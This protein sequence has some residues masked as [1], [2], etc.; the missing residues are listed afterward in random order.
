MV[1][2]T[3]LCASFGAEIHG[4]DL[5]RI[6]APQFH[7]LYALWKRHHVILFRGQRLADGE[8]DRF[9]ARFGEIEAQAESERADTEWH[10]AGAYLERPPFA[11]LMHAPQQAA[12]TGLWLASLS[13][14]LRS[15]PTDLASR[16]R[17][18]AMRHA[19]SLAM[20]EP[21]AFGRVANDGPVH[22]TGSVHPVIVVQPESGEQSLYLGNRR[23]S[24]F[25]GLAPDESERLMNIVWSYA[26][27][28]AVTLHHAWQ[29]GDVLLWNNLTTLHRHDPP[30]AASAQPPRHAQVRGRYVLTSPIQQEAA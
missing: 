23:Q 20:A 12:C 17:R 15:M 28:P 3:P 26:T 11:H 1:R 13:A 4:I 5:A 2:H 24:W 6:T 7:L 30:M 25:A 27:A 8:F 9:A 29:P 18:L 21:I 19:G 16:L 14:A 22:V 10:A